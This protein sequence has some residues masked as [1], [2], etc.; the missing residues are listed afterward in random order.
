MFESNLDIL[1]ADLDISE[2]ELAENSEDARYANEFALQYAQFEGDLAEIEAERAAAYAKGTLK[3]GEINALSGLV[4]S[5]LGQKFTMSPD[6][7]LAIIDGKAYSGAVQAQI[8]RILDHGLKVLE[9]NMFEW[10]HKSPNKEQ[11]KE[12]IEKLNNAYITT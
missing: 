4:S 11:L 2:K 3:S 9:D 6:G 5:S 12:F 7:K 1:K 8:N 10:H